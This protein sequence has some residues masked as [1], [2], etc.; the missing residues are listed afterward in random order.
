MN[1]LLQIA[2][3][4]VVGLMLTASSAAADTIIKFGLAE[5]GPDVL[6]ED[7]VFFTRDD[8]D[9]TTFGSQNTGL[10]FV[11][12]LQGVFPD[13]QEGASMTLDGVTAVGLATT[14]GDVILQQ[15]S[16]GSFSIWNEAN[17]L[18]LAGELGEGAIAGSAAADTGSFF[19][20]E[21]VNYVGGSLLALIAPSPGG[22]SISV[23]SVRTGGEIGLQI[24]DEGRLKNFTANGNGLITGDPLAQVPEPST[25]L[26]MLSGLLGTTLRKRK[27]D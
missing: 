7:G 19:N 26:L 21:V 14:T 12:F 10:N 3:V 25:V 17:E 23:A 4:S 1:K 6:Y 20:T 15:T 22:I 2:T 11:G 8:N 24:D 27:K 13:I 16:G 18:L 9:L 5:V